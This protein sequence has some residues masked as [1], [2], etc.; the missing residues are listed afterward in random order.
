[1]PRAP[2]G[3]LPDSLAQPSTVPSCTLLSTPSLSPLSLR[4][5]NRKISPSSEAPN[6]SQP[7]LTASKPALR[8]GP[9][10]QCQHSQCPGVTKF[11]HK[12]KVAAHCTAPQQLINTELGL[13]S[14]LG[15]LTKPKTTDCGVHSAYSAEQGQLRNADSA[16]EMSQNLRYSSQISPAQFSP[17]SR[18][19]VSAEA[20]ALLSLSCFI[21][22]Q[23]FQDFVPSS[24]KDISQTH[25]LWLT[26]TYLT[27]DVFQHSSF[28]LT[29]SVHHP[30][31]SHCPSDTHC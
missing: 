19:G 22:A 6:P 18:R 17:V 9:H 3:A 13:N 12:V 4:N 10:I 1:M 16:C 27:E 7:F 29:C 11:H 15:P 5:T 25:E 23:N 30:V 8:E 28:I 20:E 14:S 2:V 24:D 21:H 26:C 31:W